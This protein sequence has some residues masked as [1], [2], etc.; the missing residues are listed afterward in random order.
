MRILSKSATLLGSLLFLSLL[1]MPGSIRTQNRGHNESNITVRV[2]TNPAPV[3]GGSTSPDSVGISL[4]DCKGQEAALDHNSVNSTIPGAT[5][6]QFQINP[7]DDDPKD[8]DPKVT[9]TTKLIE[10]RDPVSCQYILRVVGHER[11]A[12]GLQLHAQGTV[13]DNGFFSLDDVPTYPESRFEV[14]FLYEA[15]PFKFEVEGGLRPADGAFSFAEPL[16]SKV[17]LPAEEKSLGVV[18]FY[19]RTLDSSSFEALLDGRDQSRRFH[20]RPGQQELVRL[21]LPSG[22]HELVIKCKK[23]DGSYAQQD[24]H[25]Q[26]G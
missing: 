22:Q 2:A 9:P 19:D 11:G 1:V 23:K 21:P 26:H 6:R 3:P 10:L 15:K 18:I 24:F 13:L 4:T 14:K 8:V 5:P 25:I 16:T 17:Q 7:D 20:P 12:Y